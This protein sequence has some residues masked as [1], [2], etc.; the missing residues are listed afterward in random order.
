MKCRA[1]SGVVVLL[2][3]LGI[4]GIYVAY[5]VFLYAGFESAVEEGVLDGVRSGTFG[6]AFGVLN[7]LFSGLAFSGV[8]ITIFLQRK[9]IRDNQI[10]S[11]RQQIEVQFY[12][13]LRL[14]QDVVR[15]FDLHRYAITGNGQAQPVVTAAGRDC[16]KSWVKA[17]RDVYVKS[18]VSDEMEKIESAYSELW[19]RHQSDLGLYYRSLYSVF[20]Y[21][22]DS[23]YVDKKRLANVARS[24]ISDYELVILFYNCVASVGG[25]RFKR[26]ACEFALFDN[27]DVGLLLNMSDVTMLDKSAFGD[28]QEALS[29]FGLSALEASAPADPDQMA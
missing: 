7:A 2:A 25:K 20:R 8:L 15:G 6:D 26:Y 5:Y 11:A 10:D 3:V 14:Q 12:N 22:S 28:N 4:F 13:L 27:L 18:V 23:E 17:L 24:L 9:D 29:A 1:S 21:I 19:R 16:F